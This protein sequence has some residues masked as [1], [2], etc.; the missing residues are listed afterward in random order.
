M[1]L[2]TYVPEKKFGSSCV[3]AFGSSCK[4]GIMPKVALE[5][6][7]SRAQKCLRKVKQL[8]FS[9]LYGFLFLFSKLTLKIPI[10]I[11]V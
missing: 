8:F 11:C 4:I 1:F 9:Y 10:Q 2:Q 3:L 5:W 6:L 7:L